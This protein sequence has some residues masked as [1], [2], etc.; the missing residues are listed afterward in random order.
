LESFLDLPYSSK[1]DGNEEDNVVWVVAWSGSFE[2][3]SFYSIL[4]DG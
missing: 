1:V 2:V 4:S 3:K